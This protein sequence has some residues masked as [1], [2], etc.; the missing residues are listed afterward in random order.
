[1]VSF[2]PLLYRVFQ[3]NVMVPIAFTV[4]WGSM[5]AQAAR[6]IGLVM[7]MLEL[8]RR[9]VSSVEFYALCAAMV[10]G[11]CESVSSSYI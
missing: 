11:L 4:A 8:H 1:M 5:A 6:L 10:I 7:L 9:R 2:N 3:C